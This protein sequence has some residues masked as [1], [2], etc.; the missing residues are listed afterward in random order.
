MKSL[1][2]NQA[3]SFLQMS[4]ST[5][6]DKVKS[7]LVPAA[8]PGKRWVFLEDDLVTFIRSLYAGGWANTVKW[9]K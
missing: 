4:P 3:A 7:G 5:L 1:S 8:K 2:L 9:L 6:R